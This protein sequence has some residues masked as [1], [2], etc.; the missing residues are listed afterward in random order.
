MLPVARVAGVAAVKRAATLGLPLIDLDEDGSSGTTTAAHTSTAALGDLLLPGDTSGG[1][2][3][4]ALHSGTAAGAGGEA[5]GGRAVALLLD[6]EATSYL[7][8]GALSPGTR[9]GFQSRARG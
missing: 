9:P 3:G 7:M 8:M 5:E 1:G 6:A 2:I 4:G